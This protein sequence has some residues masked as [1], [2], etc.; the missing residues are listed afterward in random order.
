MVEKLTGVSV[1]RVLGQKQDVL[2]QLGILV[3]VE[4]KKEG[5]QKMRQ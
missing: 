4:M 1:G 5:A 3:V 2:Q